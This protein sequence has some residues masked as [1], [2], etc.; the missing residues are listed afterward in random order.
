MIVL[1]RRNASDG[2]MGM[3]LAGLYL[4]KP[5]LNIFVALCVNKLVKHMI[6]YTTTSSVSYNFIKRRP[7]VTT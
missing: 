7:F 2:C 3:F 6:V 5:V 4:T 1:G